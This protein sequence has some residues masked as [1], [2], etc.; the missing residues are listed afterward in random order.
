M[1]AA[2]F[3]LGLSGFF[4]LALIG[5]GRFDPTTTAALSVTYLLG[6]ILGP[7][8][9]IAVEQETSRVVAGGLARGEAVTIQISRLLG[10]DVSLTIV[11]LLVLPHSR[12]YC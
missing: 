1:V 12:R 11:V 4:F 7:G 8:V 3:L 10:I 2:M 5:H 6:V 9:Y